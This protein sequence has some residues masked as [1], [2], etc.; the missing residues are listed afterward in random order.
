MINCEEADD[1]SGHADMSRYRFTLSSP[2]AN[3]T[4]ARPNDPSA[5]KTKE[6]DWQTNCLIGI[7]VVIGMDRFYKMMATE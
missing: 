1:R 5:Q 3:N 4:L 6:V 7:D 2:V